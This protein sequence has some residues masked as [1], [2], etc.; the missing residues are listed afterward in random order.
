MSLKRKIALSLSIIFL[1][2]FG[3]V[4]MIIYFSFSD[5][6]KSE[7]EG[8]FKQRLVFTIHFIAQSKD[9]EEE[10]PLFFIEDS[11][12]VLLNEQILIFNSKKKLIYSTVKDS[13]ISWDDYLLSDLDKNNTIYIEN[14][15]PE[16]YAAVRTINGEKYY[17][18]TSA[19]DVN[20]EKKLAFLKYLLLV[21]YIVSVVIIGF[22]SS[23]FLSR[24]LKP[25][26]ELN[27][28]VSDITAHNLSAQIPLRGTND[29]I[30][31]LAKSFNMMLEKL[32]DAFESQKSF[33]SSAA[34]EIR[35]PITRMAFQVENLIS[36]SNPSEQTLQT[37]EQ[38]KKDIYQMSEL[39]SSLLLLSKFNQQN[40]Q[41]VF[42]TVRI[43]D[44]IFD[45]YSKIVKSFPD[46]K[47][48]FQI[49][50]S[51]INDPSLSLRGVPSLL[52][53]VFANLLKNVSLYSDSHLATI[54]LR[55][56]EYSIY[57]DMYSDGATILEKD[58]E[59]IFKAFV[60]G[61]N[62][63]TTS[64]SGLGLPIVKKI[65]EFHNAEIKYYV[66]SNGLNAFSIGFRKKI[67]I[68]S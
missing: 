47:I 33:T 36:F 58:Q 27:R 25:L 35:T 7:F 66:S 49:S 17:I 13:E 46:L 16:V 26:E 45:A 9:F 14:S 2:L 6:R 23:Y 41:E 21:S 34:H 19:Q 10:A 37:L 59:N 28:E 30:D 48:D 1:V 54:V 24:L 51:S 65:L 60:R 64:G 22:L 67:K 50:D 56:T 29:E 4:M 68:H 11:D 52:E 5:F 20:G 18:L 44:V 12:N 53:I 43:D 39:T 62:S 55:E 38:L 63:Q 8:R 3:A 42:E 57:V 15:T 32:N 31:V 40:I 61:E